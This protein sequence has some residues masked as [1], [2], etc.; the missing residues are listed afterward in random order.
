MHNYFTK[1]RL[2]KSGPFPHFLILLNEHPRY[3]AYARAHHQLLT[4]YAPHLAPIPEPWLHATVQ[5]IHHPLIPDQLQQLTTAARA[6][7]RDIR[8]FRIQCGPVWPGITAITTA[9]YPEDGMTLLNRR[10]RYA[11]AAVPGV[12]LRPTERKFWAHSTLAYA[13]HD[14]DDHTLN[15][16]LRALRPERVDIT[17]DRVHLVNQRQHPQ[18]GYYTWEVV[19][20][21]PLAPAPRRQERA[22]PRLPYGP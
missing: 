19:A 18:R 20:D 11:A 8:P 22:M 2:W 9:I 15:R 4:R 5:G 13:R 1:E 10:A 3:R 16:E 7:F 12:K 17:I 14:F 21:F 6:A